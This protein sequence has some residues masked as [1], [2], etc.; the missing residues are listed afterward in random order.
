MAALKKRGKTRKQ[1][2]RQPQKGV[3]GAPELRFSKAKQAR[4]RLSEGL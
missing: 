2:D 1:H 4:G 3:S